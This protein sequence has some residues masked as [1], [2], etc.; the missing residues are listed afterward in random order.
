MPPITDPPIGGPA[1]LLFGDPV[2]QQAILELIRRMRAVP[3]IPQDYGS[4]APF[5][6][7]QPDRSFGYW[8]TPVPNDPGVGWQALHIL[9]IGP[10]QSAALAAAN[11]RSY[12]GLA[13]KVISRPRQQGVPPAR[14]GMGDFP[15]RV[16][17]R[18]TPGGRY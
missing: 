10:K 11:E 2:Q 9:G 14:I 16:P 1:Q 6:G 15:R 12:L 4:R 5:A 3:P 13:P 7:R 18:W 17:Y 8:Q